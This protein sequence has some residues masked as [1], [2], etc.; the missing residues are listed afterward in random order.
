LLL[1]QSRARELT[2]ARSAA[3][4]N[5]LMTKELRTQSLLLT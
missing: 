5:I 2:S 1:V 4:I 3:T